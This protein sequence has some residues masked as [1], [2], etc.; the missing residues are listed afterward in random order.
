MRA[1][2]PSTGMRITARVRMPLMLAGVL[3]LTL[4]GFVTLPAWGAWVSFAVFIAG[5]SLYLRVG[6]PRA[7]PVDVDPPVH[8]RWTAMNSPSSRIPSHRMHGWS[9]T[10]AIDLVYEPSGGHRP[11]ISWLPLARRPSDFPGFGEP[12]FAPVEG[13]VVHSVDLAR[14]HWSRTSPLGLMYLLVE[15]VRELFGPIGVLG[16]HVVI[17]RRDGVCAL[18]AHLRHGSVRVQRGQRV[19]RGTTIAECGNSGNSS[20]PHVHLQ[21]MDRSSVWIAAGL[22]FV[23]DG[24]PPPGDGEVVNAPSSGHAPI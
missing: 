21:L 19:R 5:L 17:R 13:T 24:A 22:P 1:S 6:T 14:D 11:G 4:V 7:A 10:Y 9:Q 20:E 8:G 2:K 16:N 23:F 18:V 3:L 12:I 15:G